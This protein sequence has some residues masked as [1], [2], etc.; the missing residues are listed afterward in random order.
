MATRSTI[1]VQHSNGTIS[2]VYC[3]WDGYLSHHGPLLFH[4]YNSLELAEELVS[5]GNIS[6]LSESAKPS[7]DLHTFDKP[8]SGV[9][10]YYGRD[11][12]ETD[13]EPVVYDNIDVFNETSHSEEYNYL[14][15]D[16]SWHLLVSQTKAKKITLEMIENAND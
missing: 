14:F 5:F 4:C 10:V 11:R 1:A 16:G 7:N 13:Q 8:L 15:K 6:V 9:T 12:G 3:H 2:Q